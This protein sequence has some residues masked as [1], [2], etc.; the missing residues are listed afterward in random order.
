MRAITTM[1]MQTI[2]VF[3]SSAMQYIFLPTLLNIN[4][5]I[6]RPLVKQRLRR[7]IWLMNHQSRCLY[8]VIVLSICQQSV[9]WRHGV[10]IY[11]ESALWM[12]TTRRRR[13]SRKRSWELVLYTQNCLNE[14]RSIITSAI[15]CL[16]SARVN[17]TRQRGTRFDKRRVARGHGAGTSSRLH[18]YLSRQLSSACVRSR[19][20]MDGCRCR[21]SRQN[22]P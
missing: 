14:S 13:L 2:F 6:W 4:C 22:P 9:K 19:C 7:A 8:E 15:R 12:C 18:D 3:E 11:S 16:I 5:D 20:E 17:N 21:V 10:R 1:C